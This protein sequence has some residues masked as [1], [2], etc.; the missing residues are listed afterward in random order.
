[1][2]AVRARAEAQFGVDQI[3]SETLH[4]YSQMT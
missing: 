3:V 2:R 1:M 4:L